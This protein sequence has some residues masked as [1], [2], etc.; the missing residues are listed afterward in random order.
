MLASLIAS[1]VL[2][3]GT[4]AQAS[5]ATP[6]A[7][8]PAPGPPIGVWRTG[9]DD[10]Q[11]RIAPCGTYVCGYPITPTPTAQEPERH[12]IHNPDPALRGRPM[13]LVQIFKLA[14][15]SEGFWRGWIYSPRNGKMYHARLEMQGPEKMKL[16]GCLVGPLCESQ[17]WI[18]ADAAT[19]PG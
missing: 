15:V 1:A 5:G 13:R 6:P 4:L 18:R 12:D 8:P 3:A 19:P 14:Q 2:A 17:T 7:A 10:S 16:T 9:D 11:V